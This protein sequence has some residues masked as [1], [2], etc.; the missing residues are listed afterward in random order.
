MRDVLLLCMYKPPKIIS[1]L[2]GFF[3]LIYF[4]NDFFHLLNTICTT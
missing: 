3:I 1:S 4:C 2:R